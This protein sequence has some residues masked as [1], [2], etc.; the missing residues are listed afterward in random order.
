MDFSENEI[1]NWSKSASDLEKKQKQKQV[2]CELLKA[3]LACCR[4]CMNMGDG[5][6]KYPLVVLS[7]S[8]IKIGVCPSGFCRKRNSNRQTLHSQDFTLKLFLL[9]RACVI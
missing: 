3:D 4:C 9:Y 5:A 8:A 1:E 7:N 2:S 6:L